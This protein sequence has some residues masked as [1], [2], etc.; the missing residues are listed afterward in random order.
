MAYISR[1]ARRRSS[2]S[3]ESLYLLVVLAAGVLTA[4]WAARGVGVDLSGITTVASVLGIDETVSTPHAVGYSQT[5]DQPAPYCKPGEVPAFNNGLATLKQVI[6]N[7][8]GA[9]VECE[10]STSGSGDT[11]Q[12]TTTGL[13]A[14][15]SQTNTVTFTD[16]WRHWALTPQGEVTWEGSESPPPTS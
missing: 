14:Y 10:H 12:Q 11:V 9:P 16:G 6:G 3:A 8:M 5:A 13:A 4:W 2:R 7:V 15:N 1:H